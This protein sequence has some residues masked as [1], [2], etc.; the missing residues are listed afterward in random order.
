MRSGV[1]FHPGAL[2]LNDL[3]NATVIVH[4]HSFRKK[5]RRKS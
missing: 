4:F 1:M 3:D 2:L 5:Y